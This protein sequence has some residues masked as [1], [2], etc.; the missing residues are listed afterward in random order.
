M[1][2]HQLSVAEAIASL[3]SRAEGLSTGEAGRRL[4]EY[5]PNSVEAAGRPSLAWRLGREYFHF[6]SLILWVAAG[7]AFFAEWRDPGEGMARVGATIVAVILVSGTFS[8][9]QE[10]RVEQSLATL[11]KLLPHRV[12]V[13]RD[14]AV[15]ELLAEQLVPGDVVLIETG[16]SVPAD[17]RLIEAHGVRVNTATITGESAPKAREAI[18]SQEE[19]WLASRN[20]VLAGT[21]VV[22]GR[23]RAIVFATGARTEFGRIAHLTQ[24]A[25]DTDSP[26]RVEL[27]RL[28][29]RIALIAVAIGLSFLVVG[30]ALGIPFW[31]DLIFSIGIIVAM[32]PEGL[33]PTL[34][35]A[36]VLASQRMARRQVLIRHLP[37]VETLGSATVI[38][39]DKTGTLTQ[40]HMQVRSLLLGLEPFPVEALDGHPALLEHSHRLFAAAAACHSLAE[41]LA[42]GQPTLLGDPME[43]ALVEMAR[44]FAV[45]LPVAT[46]VDEYPFDTDRMRQSVLVD[47]ADGRALYCKGA[48]ESVLPQCIAVVAGGQVRVLDDTDRSLVREAQEQMAAQG[49]RV[50]AFAFREA[51]A[52]ARSVPEADL[53]FC[54]LAGLVDPPRAEVPDAV[55]RCQSAGIRVIMVTGDHPRTAVAIARQIGLVSSPAPLVITGSELQRL[56]A[57]QLQLALDSP[58]IVFARLAADQK[59]RIVEA[60]RNKQQIVAVTGDG[61]NDAPALKAAHIG[62]AMGL[63]GTDVAKE[64]SDMIL[65]DDNFA[66]IV[67]AVEEGRA[68]FA[69]IRRFLTYVLVHNV[70][71]LVPYLAFALFR[72]PVA[73]TPIQALSID[74][75][76]DSLTALGLGAEKP[77]PQA[78]RQAPRSRGKRLLDLEL[79]WRGYLFLGVIEAAAAMS[80]FLFV[81]RQGGWTYGQMPAANDPLYLQATTATLCAIIVMQIVNVFLCRSS[82]RPV[83]STGFGGNRLIVSGVVLE[84]ALLG[85]IAYTPW[86]N[87]LFDTAPP[88][89]AVW[90][91]IVPFALVM[92]LLEEGRKA[93]VRRRLGRFSRRGD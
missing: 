36:L 46:R 27:A 22:A 64:A 20:I 71:E 91:G 3:Q 59:M 42:E 72:L 5:G 31:Q 48:P 35:L 53:V 1:K 43:I 63:S 23:G 44:R 15:V 49:L 73:L 12:E 78:M 81:L 60:L 62:I 14:G 34:T 89:A 2:I 57:T 79:A 86:G 69:N 4:A 18:E 10:L 52:G 7:L 88:P 26:L 55:R 29:R 76:T 82:V 47:G 93:I 17:C 70:A 56:S 32:V 37:A 90:I 30:S 84:V 19:Q 6:F 75:G 16:Q 54:G 74:M 92:L 13:L 87:A 85:L 33:L 25:G 68:L 45:A 40:N 66:S 39:T 38:C 24:T 80:A 51:Q 8:F 9:W 77:H 21:S 67:N 50:L 41:G 11:R 61:V 58:E 28:S 65:L 83:C